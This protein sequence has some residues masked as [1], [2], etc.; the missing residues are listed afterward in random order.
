MLTSFWLGM[1]TIFVSGV[2]YGVFAI[3]LKYSRSWRWENTWLLFCFFSMVML[4]WLLAIAFVPHLHA[5]FFG[6]PLRVLL[7]PLGFGFIL[8]FAQV[9]YGLGLVWVGLSVAVSVVSGVSCL[10]GA[11][12]PILVLHPADLLR[13]RGILLLVS[14]PI[15]LLGVALYGLAGRHREKEQQGL[16]CEAQAPARS[17]ATGLAICIFTG[18]FGSSINLGFAFS[19][20]IIR[21]SIELGGTSTTSTFAVWTLVFGASFIPN[22]VYCSHLLFHDATW[23]RYA[24]RGWAREAA[25]ALIMAV[26]SLGAFIGYGRGALI[27]GKYGTS[28]GWALFVA[29]N[30]VASTVAG[31]LMGEWKGTSPNTRRLLFAAVAVLL[32]TVVIL[33]MGGLL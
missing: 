4:P 27:M 23:S 10:M 2:A 1:A 15:L 24:A 6:T 7:L 9:A 28:V 14:L 29:A 19:G 3:P 16:A 12:I 18:V 26:L 20:D 31:L 13:P 11:L 32:F 21:R 25:F 33:N 30:V 5:L 8:G 22:L 17:F